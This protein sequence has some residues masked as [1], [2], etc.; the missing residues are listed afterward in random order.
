SN[1]PATAPTRIPAPSIVLAATQVPTQLPRQTPISTAKSNKPLLIAGVAIVLLLVVGVAAYQ[2]FNPT[3]HSSGGSSP[4]P[5][6]AQS[7][8]PEAATPSEAPHP[9][10]HLPP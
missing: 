7:V 3:P 2:I 4:V 5:S 8:S 9:N 1:I 10:Q 6:P